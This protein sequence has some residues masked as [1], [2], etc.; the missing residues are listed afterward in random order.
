MDLKKTSVN[1]LRCLCLPDESVRQT[2]KRIENLPR[3]GFDVVEMGLGRRS[4]S[5]ASI[6]ALRA[7]TSYPLILAAR[8]KRLTATRVKIY[9][10]AICHGWE[11]IDVDMQSEKKI[12][13]LL[14]KRL[15]K[16][17]A[18]TKL[19][20]SVHN[21]I[22]TTSTR[23]IENWIERARTLGKKVPTLPKVVVKIVERQDILRIRNIALKY[24]KRN[25]GVV[26]HGQGEKSRG[27]RLIQAAAGSAITYLC[28]SEKLSTSKGQ[29]TITDWNRRIRQRKPSTRK[30]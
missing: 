21:P 4:L 6:R 12:L 17:G 18:K 2:M 3:E 1:P 27:S 11:W 19:I 24:A 28:L 10:Q 29:W 5:E 13:Q 8:G 7:S 20:L 9:E 14:I 26:L 22:L 25:I 30:P 15:Q 23:M 16:K